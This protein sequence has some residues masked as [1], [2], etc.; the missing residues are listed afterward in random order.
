[1]KDIVI[2]F[3]KSKDKAYYYKRK[4]NGELYHYSPRN[5]TRDLYI[6]ELESIEGCFDEAFA[7]MYPY[8]LSYMDKKES[9][10]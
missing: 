3:F 9:T 8:C 7:E 5:K 4:F 1:M 10:Q 6:Y 2:K